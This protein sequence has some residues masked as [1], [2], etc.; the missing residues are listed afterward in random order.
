[1]QQAARAST[2][3][4]KDVLLCGDGSCVGPRDGG[5]GK[6]VGAG[7]RNHNLEVSVGSRIGVPVLVEIP[8]DELCR[9][10]SSSGTQVRT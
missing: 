4:S 1:M 2:T 8:I 9:Q 7:L 3:R 5:V 6:W 10:G